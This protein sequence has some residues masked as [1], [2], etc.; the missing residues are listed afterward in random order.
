MVSHPTLKKEGFSLYTETLNK[1]YTKKDGLLE[2]KI[3]HQMHLEDHLL[4]ITKKGNQIDMLKNEIKYMRKRIM[5]AENAEKQ[6]RLEFQMYKVSV[7]L[8]SSVASFP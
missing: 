1:K 3:N 8:N 5:Q 2:P 4:L 6:S 7:Q